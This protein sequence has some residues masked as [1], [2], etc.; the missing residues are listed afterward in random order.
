[1]YKICYV[2]SFGHQWQDIEL[3]SLIILRF[4]SNYYKISL[5]I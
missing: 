2:S 4:G 5:K 3:D 1:M